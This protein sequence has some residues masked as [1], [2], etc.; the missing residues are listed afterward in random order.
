MNDRLMLRL[1]LS[2]LLATAAFALPRTATRLPQDAPAQEKSTG[3]P[4]STG[5]SIAVPLP[6]GTRIFL[7]D[8]NYLL[9]REYKV[10]G[11]RVR[12]W[13]VER[14]AWEEVPAQLVDWDATHKGEAEDV[15]R[16]KQIDEKLKEIAEHAR[17]T[18][19][20]I[21]TS[22]EVAPGVYLP[23]EVGFYVVADGAVVSLS[24][25]LADSHL[26]KRRLLVQV[27]SPVPVIPSKHNVDLKGAHATLR[28][29]DARPEFYFRT[30]DQR[31]P[32][33]ALIRAQVHGDS[34]RISEI[35]T[36]AVTGQSHSKENQMPLERWL[37]ARGTF[38]YTLGKKLEP[39]EYAF[40]ENVMDRGMDLYVWDFGVDAPGT[41]TK[42]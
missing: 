7:K 18:S 31:E 20:D 33:V 36:L 13:S 40:I 4:S 22:I 37:I 27:L 8:G 26:S 3:P 11:D 29:R 30:P 10:Q 12:Y 6:Q 16:K 24:Q 28:F 14:S 9:A 1:L 42:K 15:E 25:D 5:E 23:D 19:L 39:G 38:R 34:R 35:S 17:A 21:D 32:N 41:A 2:L